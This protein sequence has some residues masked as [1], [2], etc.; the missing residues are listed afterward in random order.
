MEH[1]PAL[2]AALIEE[3]PEKKASFKATPSLM[4]AW[5]ECENE[6][7]PKSK[8]CSRDCSNKNARWRYKSRKAA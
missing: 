8:Y 5:R 3:A 6:T 1:R 4:C 7:R 2:E